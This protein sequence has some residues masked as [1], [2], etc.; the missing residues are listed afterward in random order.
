MFEFRK[1]IET[2]TAA[3]AAMRAS[4]DMVDE[5]RKINTQMEASTLSL[6]HI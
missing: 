5:M 1:I 4:A 3:L 6:I 2:Q